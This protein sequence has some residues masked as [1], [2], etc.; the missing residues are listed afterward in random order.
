MIGIHSLSKVGRLDGQVITWSNGTVWSKLQVTL[1]NASFQY[2][3][4][5]SPIWSGVDVAL[6]ASSRVGI[7]GENGCGKSTLLGV[8]TRSLRSSG[9][10][11]SHKGLRLAHVAQH[12]VHHLEKCLSST[13]LEYMQL[14]FRGGYD[15]ETVRTQLPQE[16]IRR[17]QQLGAKNGKRGKAVETL[18]SRITE[19][20]GHETTFRYEVKWQDLPPID[21]TLLDVVQLKSLGAESLVDEFDNLL[22]DCWGAGAARPLTTCEVVQHLKCFGLSSDMICN[23]KISMLSAGEKC[24]LVFGAAF[25]VCPHILCLDEPTNYLDIETVALLQRSIRTFRGACVVVTHNERFVQEVCN[26]VW[27]IEAGQV[28]I[29]KQSCE[30]E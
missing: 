9:E 5:D 22:W 27:E 16:E 29:R 13:P 30:A 8:L 23:R 4:A 2:D 19:D 24:K 18:L 1:Q 20:V 7:V 11:W 10:L 21:N 14:R 6:T 17:M 25:W 15:A 26:E 3:G 12:S 28:K